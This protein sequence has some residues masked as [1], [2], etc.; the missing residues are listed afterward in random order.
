MSIWAAHCTL[1]NGKRC[2][3]ELNTGLVSSY[4]V[5]KKT[6]FCLFGLHHCSWPDFSEPLCTD[7][8]F[9]IWIYQNPQS[10]TQFVVF[11]VVTPCSLIPWYHSFGGIRQPVILKIETTCSTEMSVSTDNYMKSQPRRPH[12]NTSFCVNLDSYTIL[13]SRYNFPRK[14]V[15]LPEPHSTVFKIYLAERRLCDR[16]G[17]RS[18]F[19]QAVIILTYFVWCGLAKAA[20][21]NYIVC[22]SEG[23]KYT[24]FTRQI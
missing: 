22:P 12:L 23:T 16:N 10:G 7:G 9:I 19:M 15:S 6:V 20:E 2:R 17:T 21:E 3:V 13:N 1:Y 24:Y 8:V 4:F 14:K 5:Q 18:A 11:W